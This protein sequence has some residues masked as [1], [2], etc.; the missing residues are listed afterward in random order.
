MTLVE[1]PAF[2]FRTAR[3]KKNQNQYAVVAYF[4]FKVDR[5][6]LYKSE[7]CTDFHLFAGIKKEF[8]TNSYQISQFH[9]SISVALCNY[10]ERNCTKWEIK[11]SSPLSGS[12]ATP[13]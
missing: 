5:L 8:V 9:N 4:D 2:N 7:I 13:T 3:L 12:Q 6:F 11:T 10:A 1:I